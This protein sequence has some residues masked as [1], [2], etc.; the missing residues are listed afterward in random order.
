MQGRFA[1]AESSSTEALHL[2]QRIEHPFA[3]ACY[4]GQMMQIQRDR[5]EIHNVQ[6]MFAAAFDTRKGP[7]HWVR[8]VLGRA[9]LALGNE[10]RAREILELLVEDG[11]E[12]I[13]R[14]IRF[15]SSIVEMA[16]LCA[17]LESES[18]AGAFHEVLRSI[19]GLHAVLPVPVN[20]GGPVALGLARISETLGRSRDAAQYFAEAFAASRQLGAAPTA[21]RIGV[22]WARLLARQ[23]ERSAARELASESQHHAQALDMR[24]VA[25]QADQLR[26]RL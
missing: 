8:A 3:F 4:Q 21:T 14:G 24:A 12:N 5:G 22:E 18:H 2:G 25:E 1:E 16:L 9:E 7:T 10:K 26:K 11:L 17:E 23:G 6:K 13:V 19:E 20:Y 15:V